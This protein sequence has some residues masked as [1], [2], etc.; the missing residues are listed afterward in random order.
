MDYETW[1]NSQ[2]SNLNDVQTAI[3]IAS[4]CESLLANYELFCY[5][6]QWGDPEKLKVSISLMYDSY[7]GIQ[8]SKDINN[9]SL[10]IERVTPDLDD[11]ED[12]LASYAFDACISV[13]EG[14]QF[15]IT[16]DRLH[17]K[18]ACLCAFDSTDMFVQEIRGLNSSDAQFEEKLF[19]DELMQQEINRQQQIVKYL[20]TQ[21]V[22]SL[23]TV[24]HVKKINVFR[25]PLN[26]IIQ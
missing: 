6:S 14:L 13:A 19:F 22:V 11:F 2:L 4:C 3:H 15:L 8:I 18:N 1:V 7:K 16:K 10:S 23:E 25:L 26:L 21:Q 24:M 9:I 17:A 20:C 12:G 5:F